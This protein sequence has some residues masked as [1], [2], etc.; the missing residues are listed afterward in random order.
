MPRFLL[1]DAGVRVRRGRRRD[2]AAVQA[3]LGV[4]AASDRLERWFRRIVADLGTD[5]YVAEDAAGTVIGLVSVV[6]ARSLVQGGLSATL[7]GARA[8][9]EPAGPLLDGLVAFAEERAR[10][11]GC[12][13]LVACV[14]SDDGALRAALVAR[15]YRAGEL[16]VTDLGGRG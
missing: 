7:D 13:R 12:R 5:I 3:L 14:P 4:A 16:L 15:G 8:R 1:P 9:R 2:L 6:Y 11:R 10:K